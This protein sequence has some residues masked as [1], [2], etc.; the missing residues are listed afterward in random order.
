[1]EAFRSI[2]FVNHVLPVMNNKSRIRR[3]NNGSIDES[4]AENDSVHSFSCTKLRF[5]FI[6]YC[7]YISK[8]RAWYSEYNI[9]YFK[10]V[11]IEKWPD[12]PYSISLHTCRL[13]CFRINHKPDRLLNGDIESW[14][15]TV[16][17]GGIIFSPQ[18]H[19][20]FLAVGVI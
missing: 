1:M 5:W 16:H 11:K 9:K 18:F 19:G 13:L 12:L 8:L 14:I 4:S 6:L 10:R 15:Y 2:R 17:K 20:I 7:G 3:H